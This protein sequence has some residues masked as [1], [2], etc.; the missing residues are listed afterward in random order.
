MSSRLKVDMYS[1]HIL[2]NPVLALPE[3]S[4][5]LCLVL[6][7]RLRNSQQKEGIDTK[8]QQKALI[9]NSNTD[10]KLYFYNPWAYS[11]TNF[12]YQNMVAFQHINHWAKS[13]N[14]T[15]KS[16]SSEMRRCKLMTT[17]LPL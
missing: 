2:F 12:L 13:K 9:Q 15:V 10:T 7:Y 11:T 5:T 6:R 8:S 4:K 14:M 17:D 3:L 1:Y 16:D